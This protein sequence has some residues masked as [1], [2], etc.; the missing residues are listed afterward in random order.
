VN[1]ATSVRKSVIEK[2][3]ILNTR[4]QKRSLRI[5]GESIAFLDLA[6]DPVKI[7]LVTPDYDDDIAGTIFFLVDRKLDDRRVAVFLCNGLVLKS[8]CVE[9]N[10]LTKG[11][12]HRK[13]FYAPVKGCTSG[14]NMLNAAPASRSRHRLPSWSGC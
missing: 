10:R 2:L 1:A 8:V 12:F 5:G 6:D 3:T 7:Y 14:S 9:T 11:Y 4:R 13:G